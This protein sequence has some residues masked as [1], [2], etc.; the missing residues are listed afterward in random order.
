MT[1]EPP[2]TPAP[3]PDP[4]SQPTVPTAPV[5]SPMSNMSGQTMVMIAAV[6]VL[7][8]Y[9]IFGLIVDEW[10]PSFE[11][12]IAASFAVILPQVKAGPIG[13]G[14]STATLMKILGYVIAVVGL[15]DFI[16]T[17]RFGW[18]GFEDV[19]AWLLLLGSAIVAFL[20]ARSIET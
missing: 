8:V 10:Y 9:V 16:A 20:G 6:V 2:A 4:A 11:A 3:E 13:S 14:I 18:G 1:S 12:V 5:A 15:W 7:G 19:I 17:L